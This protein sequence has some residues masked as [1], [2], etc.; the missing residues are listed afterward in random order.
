MLSSSVSQ[1]SHS[2]DDITAHLSWFEKPT[3]N[4]SASGGPQAVNSPKTRT[5]VLSATSHGSDRAVSHAPASPHAGR[6]CQLSEIHGPAAPLSTGIHDYL[7]DCG[8]CCT[9]SGETETSR[10]ELQRSNSPNC[11]HRPAAKAHPVV[12]AGE[13]SRICSPR[14]DPEKPCNHRWKTGLAQCNSWEWASPKHRMD[15]LIPRPGASELYCATPQS[16]LA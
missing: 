16:G 6:I 13:Q 7:I 9:G 1:G 5:P 15:Q 2:T 14:A 12:P 10:T 11:Q 4:F 8:K 3:A